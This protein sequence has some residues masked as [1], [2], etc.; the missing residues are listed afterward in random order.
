MITEEEYYNLMCGGKETMGTTFEQIHKNW[1]DCFHSFL[2]RIDEGFNDK[3][4]KSLFY[5][6]DMSNWPA[7]HKANTEY[8]DYTKDKLIDSFLEECS[9]ISD[10]NSYDRLFRTHWIFRQAFDNELNKVKYLN[11]YGLP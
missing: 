3:S 8:R 10:R 2:I 7:I 11:L 1:Y 4:I 6:F 5:D 9:Y